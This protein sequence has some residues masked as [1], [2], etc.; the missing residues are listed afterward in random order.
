[1]ISIF[2]A[3]L[4]GLVYGVE[5]LLLLQITLHQIYCGTPQ[6]PEV[7]TDLLEDGGLHPKL[8][9]AV[10]A[11]AVFDAVAATDAC[12]S[13]GSNL[14]N[15]LISVRDGLAQGIIRQT[16]WADTQDMLAD[17]LTKVGID[18][19]LLHQVSNKCPFKLAH[20]AQTH[21]KISIGSTTNAALEQR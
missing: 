19:A 8:D 4:N 10:D 6:S 21:S 5:P 2:S 14:K 1:M 12:E 9:I 18:R 3:E 20:E 11:R 7:M 15:H 17:G 16:H 13:Q